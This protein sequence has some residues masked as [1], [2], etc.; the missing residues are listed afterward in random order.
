MLQPTYKDAVLRKTHVEKWFLGFRNGPLLLE[1]HLC[2]GRPSTPLTNENTTK[3]FELNVGY[4]HRTTDEHVISASWN[5]PTNESWVIIANENSCS[6]VWASLARG[7]ST[8][9][10]SVCVPWTE[11][12]LEVDS[13]NFLLIVTGEE[14][15]C[16]DCDPKIKQQSSQR[17]HSMPPCLGERIKWKVQRLEDADLLHR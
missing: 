8:A 5:S 2:P 14:S 4:H 7:K 17:K 16:Y 6:K 1:D 15:R 12:M 10:T 11:K 9:A 13:D 3:T